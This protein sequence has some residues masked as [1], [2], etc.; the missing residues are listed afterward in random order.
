MFRSGR[1]FGVFREE[2]DVNVIRLGWGGKV[3][4]GKG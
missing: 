4:V 1:G 3:E 2:L